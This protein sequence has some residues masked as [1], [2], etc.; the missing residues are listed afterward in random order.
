[1]DR[2]DRYRRFAKECLELVRTPLSDRSKATLLQM[3][4]VWNRLA[5]EHERLVVREKADRDKMD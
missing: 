4:H 1:M 2:S 5:D 3:A